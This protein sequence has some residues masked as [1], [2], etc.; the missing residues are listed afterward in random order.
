MYLQHA[1]QEKKKNKWQELRFI[2][3][4]PKRKGYAMQ[5]I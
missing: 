3:G 5:T 4:Y 2:R 1:K